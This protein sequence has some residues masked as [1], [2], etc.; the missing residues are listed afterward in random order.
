MAHPGWCDNLIEAAGLKPG[1][2]VLVVVDEPLLPEGSELTAA[3]KDAGGEPRLELWDGDRPL[4]EPPA[5]V[6]ETARGADV[7]F[8]LSEK[9][10]ADEAGARFQLLGDVTGNGGRQIFMGF[11]DGPLLRGQLSEPGPDLA[12]AA[13][14]AARPGRG[15]RDDPHPRGSRH[16]P[17]PPD[18]RAPLADGRHGLQPGHSANYPGGGSSSRRTG[19]RRRR[20]RGRPDR[21]VYGHGLVDE[22]VTMRFERGRVT[23]SRRPRRRSATRHRRA[24]RRGRGRDRRA[25]DRA[26]PRPHT[27]RPRHARREAPAPPMSRSGATP[28]PTAVTTRPRSTS[29]ASSRGRSSRRTGDR[30]IS[31]GTCSPRSQSATTARSIRT[32]L[33]LARAEA[34]GADRRPPRAD[35]QVR[36]RVRQVRVDLHRSRRYALIWGWQFGVAS[37]C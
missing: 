35:R 17:D 11:V 23:R 33:A 14:Q 13:C 25:R 28:A 16:G 15:R 10:R 29:T 9:P 8:F 26:E 34:L 37:C 21:S 5:A 20:A 12:E 1:E 2:R 19:R 4:T 27:A 7:S 3:V 30:S 6:R 18:R 31:L 32:G 22:P 36:L 24:G